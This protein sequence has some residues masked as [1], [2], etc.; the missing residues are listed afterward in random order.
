MPIGKGKFNFDEYVHPL[1]AGHQELIEEKVK[2]LSELTESP[3]NL[4]V[5]PLST[6][7][8]H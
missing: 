3:P 8:I 1:Q 7:D 4:T 6:S 2:V 5:I